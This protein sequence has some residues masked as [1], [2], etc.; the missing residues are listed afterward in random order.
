[1]KKGIFIVL[2]SSILCSCTGYK[3][4]VNVPKGEKLDF[5][6]IA[7]VEIGE[8]VSVTQWGGKTRMGKLTYIDSI[9]LSMKL[10]TREMFHSNL[11]DI[12]VMKY[13]IDHLKTAGNVA[14]TGVGIAAIVGF[15]MLLTF[16]NK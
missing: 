4:V 15:I 1:M 12:K 5:T 3:S 7:D 2:L 14:T 6:E 9:A 13:D 8:S 11:S 10:P 16:L